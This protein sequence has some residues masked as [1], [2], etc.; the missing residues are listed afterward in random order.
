MSTRTNRTHHTTP[1]ST[2]CGRR[3]TK[4]PGPGTR[5][6]AAPTWAPVSR[7]NASSQ[8]KA[9]IA[10]A[11]RLIQRQHS[12]RAARVCAASRSAQSAALSHAPHVTPQQAALALCLQPKICAAAVHLFLET[13]LEQFLHQRVA[14]RGRQSRARRGN[15]VR[16]WQ[17]QRRC[18]RRVAQAK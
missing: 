9:A 16:R 6:R 7:A 15:V 10:R 2:R 12:R 11:T 18:R 1:R 3:A 8:H 17:H 5:R 4:C 14:R 13:R